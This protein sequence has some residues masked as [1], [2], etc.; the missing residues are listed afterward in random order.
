MKRIIS[1]LLCLILIFGL[2]PAREARAD[3]DWPENVS[4]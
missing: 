3:G 2:L 1:V 4:I